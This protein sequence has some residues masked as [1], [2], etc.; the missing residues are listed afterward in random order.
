MEVTFA[1]TLASYSH[2][3]N[4]GWIQTHNIMISI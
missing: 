3:Q 2:A 4:I 1:K